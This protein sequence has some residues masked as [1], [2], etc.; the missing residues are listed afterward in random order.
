M[1]KYS[2]FNQRVLGCILSCAL[3][4]IMPPRIAS[5]S[6]QVI[7]A[8]TE[9]PPYYGELLPNQGVITEIVREA[10]KH[11]GYEVKIKFLPWKRALEMTRQGEFNALFTAW[12]RKEREQWF[13]FSD[14][15][16]IVNEIGFYKR[17]DRKVSYRTIEDLQAYKIG[18]V[19]GYSNPAEFDRAKLDTEEVTEDRLNIQKLAVGRID[20]A[21]IDKIIG[22]HIIDTELPESAQKLEWLDPPLKIDNQYLMFSKKFDDYQEKIADF[23]RGLRQIIE[24][25]IVKAIIV[26][27]GFH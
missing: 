26:K 24:A 23:N 13:G 14:P 3:I 21:L 5:A 4:G 18:I 25:G 17:K 6:K 20:L 27:H 7:L 9:Y 8:T 12:Y 19:R 16:P 10:F 11:A 15:L 2:R 1:K 22:Q